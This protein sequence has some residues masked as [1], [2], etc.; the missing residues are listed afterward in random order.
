MLSVGMY[1]DS[2]GG[3]VAE[4]VRSFSI[5]IS[6]LKLKLLT[7]IFVLS[8]F[9]RLPFLPFGNLLTWNKNLTR[10]AGRSAAKQAKILGLTS[11]ELGLGGR[12]GVVNPC[13]HR[14][15]STLGEV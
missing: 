3:L 9:R 4:Y 10:S 15:D 6:I 1:V 5:L 13:W 2:V 8:S 12:L 14:T 7:G 11:E